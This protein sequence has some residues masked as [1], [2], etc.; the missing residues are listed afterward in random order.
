MLR[1]KYLCTAGW[2]ARDTVCLYSMWAAVEFTHNRGV[3]LRPGT[4]HPRG[5]LAGELSSYTLGERRLEAIALK[6]SPHG[7]DDLAV[8]Y[9]PRFVGVGT[10]LFRISGLERVGNPPAWV[11]QE[12]ICTPLPRPAHIAGEPTRARR[13]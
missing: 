12:W 9:R 10:D 5:V 3:K 1:P 13:P 2:N 11:H 7:G 6:P 4:E 8:I